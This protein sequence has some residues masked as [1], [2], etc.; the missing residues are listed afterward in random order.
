MSAENQYSLAILA[1]LL[2]T[3]CYKY[4]RK[5]C[6]CDELKS[7]K[8]SRDVKRG[9]KLDCLLKFHRQ[10]TVRDIEAIFVLMAFAVLAEKDLRK[11]NNKFFFANLILIEA[12]DFF[13]CCFFFII[14]FYL[15]APLMYV[16]LC[17]RSIQK[18]P[19]CSLFFEA[20]AKRKITWQRMRRLKRRGE[21]NAAG[22]FHLT[23]IRSF[24]NDFPPPLYFSPFS[25]IHNKPEFPKL[26][27]LLSFFFR[28]CFQ[29]HTFVLSLN[30]SRGSRDKYTAC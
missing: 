18:C 24:W 29:A 28:L 14:H 30:W 11:W 4:I 21:N 27:F 10:Q 12:I 22:K 16:R 23:V 13:H 1:F 6:C 2:A 15:P 25:T 7:M 19:I 20:T 17:S 26:R 8:I 5:V 3:L 9:K